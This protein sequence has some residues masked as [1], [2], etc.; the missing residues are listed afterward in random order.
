M[1]SER[2][3]RSS[4]T[5]RGDDA[6]QETKVDDLEVGAVDGVPAAVA[7]QDQ[8]G[9]MMADSAAVRGQSWSS[10]VG[11]RAPGWVERNTCQSPVAMGSPVP[12]RRDHSAT[13]LSPLISGVMTEP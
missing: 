11:V 7:H 5:C 3:V 6:P 2:P 12:T 8:R 4:P 13:E 10:T 1:W 9:P